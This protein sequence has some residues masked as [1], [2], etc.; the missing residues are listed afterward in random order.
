MSNLK[1]FLLDFMF[2][3]KRYLLLNVK[4]KV[5]RARRTTD[6]KTTN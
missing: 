1:I 3:K 4:V 2:P 5:F 6:S